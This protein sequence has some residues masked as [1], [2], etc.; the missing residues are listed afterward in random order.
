MIDPSD[1]P[2]LLRLA[3][4]TSVQLARHACAFATTSG[5]RLDVVEEVVHNCI[6]AAAAIGAA[7]ERNRLVYLWVCSG[8]LGVLIGFG[9]AAV[10][11]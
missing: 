4:S 5:M 3:N 6:E 8:L 9:I 2:E 7:R 1:G 10:T 11:L